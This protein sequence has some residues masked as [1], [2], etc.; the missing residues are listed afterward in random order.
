MIFA[1]TGALVSLNRARQYA[2]ACRL[3]QKWPFRW[4]AITASQSASSMLKLILSRRIPALFT[5]MSSPPNTLTAWSTM[6]PAPSKS[7]T[8]S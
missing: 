3:G 4:T 2:A 7:V 5:R 8:L 1:L 6:R